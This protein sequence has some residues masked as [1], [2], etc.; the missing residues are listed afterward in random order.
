M[1]R[2]SEL[3]DASPATLN[4]ARQVLGLPTLEAQ[5][6]EQGQALAAV[7][8]TQ[9]SQATALD[10]VSDTLAAHTLSA[11][12]RLQALEEAVEG[13][14]GPA[15]MVLNAD[16]YNTDEDVEVV[17]NVLD[18]DTTNSGV[19]QVLQF[20]Y[21]GQTGSTPAGTYL[22]IP[23]VGELIM[24]SDGE[25]NFE[26][27]LNYNGP[28]PVITYM[29]TNGSET[30][31]ST[32]TITI[33][34]INDPPVAATNSTMTAVNDPVTF[35]I[36]G[37]DYD[38]EG[39]AISLTHINGQP[40]TV[41]V[42]IPVPNGTVIRNANHTL[43]F[44]PANNFA[45]TVVFPYTI[46][47]GVLSSD[48]TVNITVGFEN[49]P[50]FSPVAPIAEG[51]YYDE[52]AVNFGNTAM[53]RVGQLYNN[54]TNVTDATYT[55]AQGNFD[56]GQR[57]PWL[58]D[59]ATQVYKLYLRTQDPTIRA[60]A[61]EYAELYMSGVVPSFAGHDF[62][63]GG[64]TAGDPKYLYPIIA[65]WYERET[66]DARY[67]PQARGLYQQCMA[68]FPIAY[69][70]QAALWTERNM[71]FCIQACLAQHWITGEAQP[72]ADAEAYFNTLV[73]MAQ[74]TGAPLH[75]HSQHEGS[76]IGTPV[77]SPWMAAMMI[78]TLIQLYRTNSDNRI[79]QWIA[80]YGDFVV[81]HAFY[82]NNQVAA[83]LGM[84][85]PAY[86]VGTALRYQ[87]D[88]GP[89]GDA[90]HCYDV[91]I[92]LQK[93][94][95]AKQQLG[96]NTE[97]M[98][99]VVNEMMTV[100]RIIFQ[101][102]TRNTTGF[103]RYRVNPPRKYGWW[104]NGSYTKIPYAGPV[105]LG[106]IPITVPAIT[107]ATP[108]GSVLTVTPGT[109]SNT[110]TPALTYQWRRG[111]VDIE[112]ATDT[113]YTL[114][115]DDVG[116]AVSVVETATNA[117]GTTQ[118]TSSTSII[119]TPSGS[120]VIDTQ[121]TS[122]V[123]PEGD[124]AVF[125]VVA[126]G[127][128]APSYQWE[129]S[130]N[131]GSSWSDVGGATA[132]TL[133]V[134]DLNASNSGAHY[135]CRVYNTGDTVYSAVVTLHVSVQISAVQFNETEGAALSSA[136]LAAGANNFTIEALV[137]FNGPRIGGRRILTNRYVAGRMANL[138]THNNFPDYSL[139]V[140]DSQTGFSG[141][142]LSAM[143]P[144]GEWVFMTLTADSTAD[145]GNFRA[146]WQGLDTEDV[147]VAQQRVK[148]LTG[149]L[150][151][152]GFEIN[153]GGGVTEGLNNIA[154][155]YVRA[156]A[157]DRHAAGQTQTDRNS[158]D[159]TGALFWWVFE[160]NGSGGVAVRDVTGNNRVPAITGGTLVAGPVVPAL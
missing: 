151:H 141:G 92:M 97:V 64:G 46:S 51:D 49:I 47:D 19:L 86:L 50:L 42:S 6:G 136:L 100:A 34:N 144:D 77:T 56:L 128:P 106:P 149:A 33:N 143:P 10:T 7:E 36:L 94:I 81:D 82:T 88:G 123:L 157:N 57:E 4:A 90:E 69:S 131:G 75:P 21:Q 62:S 135:R 30:R 15:A 137:R 63:T 2:F 117:G 102:W 16:T 60:K 146:S 76:S 23:G 147:Q 17:G 93:C 38:P 67:R 107:G 112:G 113:T 32:L 85:V 103:P 148:G 54:G 83:F 109:Y 118:R 48:G 43:T 70:P 134:A 152:V 156:Y 26:P 98:Q 8:S 39:E 45:G 150:S 41:G 91:G 29:A 99:G 108:V 129:I 138:G 55:A 37:N 31:L 1:P 145:I 71:N 9:A 158:I 58:Y 120:P 140:G 12:A 65:W 44:T 87:D 78:E 139:A 116:V 130:T 52:A 27:G 111:G 153:G 74:S 5:V 105:V 160:D 25:F 115:E 101:E 155:Q 53:G 119:A 125:T 14:S 73:T 79:V 159:T 154:Y 110:V 66:G 20:W 35:D 28:V 121:P 61:L 24:Y 84:R 104:F 114:T 133:T 72:L 80:R 127:S 122:L 124:D 126:S 95:W 11:N 22:S 132:A 59:R 68:S 96:Q 3:E 89:S 18:N 40:A 13:L 142:Q